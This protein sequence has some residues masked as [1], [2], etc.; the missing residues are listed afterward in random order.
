MSDGEQVPLTL[1]CAACGTVQVIRVPRERGVP[2]GRYMWECFDC[3]GKSAD[4]RA[5]GR[6]WKKHLRQEHETELPDREEK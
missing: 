6:P 5:S 3:Q 4:A 1:V 2:A